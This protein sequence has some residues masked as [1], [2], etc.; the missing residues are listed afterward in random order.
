LSS[1]GIYPLQA[2]DFIYYLEENG[3][4]SSLLN[5]ENE[6]RLLDF[7][8]QRSKTYKNLSE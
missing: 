3:M 4:H 1:F 5:Q 7:M 8:L 2:N 6:M